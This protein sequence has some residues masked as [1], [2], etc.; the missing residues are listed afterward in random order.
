MSDANA[1]NE[2]NLESLYLLPA[3]GRDVRYVYARVINLAEVRGTVQQYIPVMAR[4]LVLDGSHPI[5]WTPAYGELTHQILTDW[6]CERRRRERARAMLAN[7]ASSSSSSSTSRVGI[8]ATN[9]DDGIVTS[10]DDD[11]DMLAAS[12]SAADGGSP[13]SQT[14]SS[15]LDQSGGNAA[16]EANLGR[17][18]CLVTRMSR[19]AFGKRARVI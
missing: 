4:P 16:L 1:A 8:R 15:S 6:I 11:A 19:R 13:N 5:S 18:T 14:G 7:G 17:S 12:N 9:D 10:G 3:N 2:T